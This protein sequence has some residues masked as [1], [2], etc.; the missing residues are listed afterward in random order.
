MSDRDLSY[1]CSDDEQGGRLGGVLDFVLQPVVEDEPV[2]GGQ[3]EVRLGL[4][5]SE[6]IG[7]QHDAHGQTIHVV[8][9]RLYAAGGV[10][11]H[12]AFLTQLRT[13]PVNPS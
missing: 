6:A 3:F 1:R 13:R 5:E 9:V 10:H 7:M 8:D 2:A 12:R 11:V 4:L